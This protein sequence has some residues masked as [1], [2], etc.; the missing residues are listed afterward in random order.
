MRTISSG[1]YIAQNLLRLFANYLINSPI[2]GDTD[3]VAGEMNKEVDD[4][5]RVQELFSPKKSQIYDV[6]YIT[7]LK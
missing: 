5:S 4:I 2:K 1:S 7:L 3:W 6:P